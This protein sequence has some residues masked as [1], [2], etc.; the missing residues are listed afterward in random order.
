M[1]R[2]LTVC[3]LAIFALLMTGGCTVI[4]EYSS[5]PEEIKVPAREHELA[6]QLLQA[7]VKNDAAA[8]VALKKKED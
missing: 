2:L 8:F 4:R 1:F 6:R 3:T 7:F 5:V